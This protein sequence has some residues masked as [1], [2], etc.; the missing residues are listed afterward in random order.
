MYNVRKMRCCFIHLSPLPDHLC[1]IKHL[2]TLQKLILRYSD[3]VF[4]C[5]HIAVTEAENCVTWFRSRYLKTQGTC[6]R[7]QGTYSGNDQ[8]T[9]TFLYTIPYPGYIFVV[10]DTTKTNS[11]Q[12]LQQKFTK[13]VH[14]NLSYFLSSKCEQSEIETETRFIMA[15]RSVVHI[16]LQIC[17]DLLKSMLTCAFILSSTENIV[18]ISINFFN[19]YKSNYKN[20]YKDCRSC[21]T[22]VFAT[23]ET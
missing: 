1:S 22:P 14:E 20:C 12:G 19:F 10:P 23:D 11:A 8:K 7:M 16:D 18:Y 4:V 6:G 21:F 13:L 3:N 5:R 17:L 2:Y 9:G 15:Q